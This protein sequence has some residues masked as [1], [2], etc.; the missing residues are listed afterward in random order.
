MLELQSKISMKP[1]SS[2]ETAC[3][4]IVDIILEKSDVI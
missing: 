2:P 3:L 4:S 1:K